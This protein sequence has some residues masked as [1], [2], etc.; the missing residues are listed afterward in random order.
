MGGAV[1][2]TGT[3]CSQSPTTAVTRSNPGTS[4]FVALGSNR[5]V[6]TPVS[7]SLSTS[8]R[9]T[10]TKTGFGRCEQRGCGRNDRHRGCRRRLRTQYRLRES[11][12]QRVRDTR[13]GRRSRTVTDRRR[14][15]FRTNPP[16]PTIR[17]A[18]PASRLTLSDRPVQE[19]GP[20]LSTGIFSARFSNDETG[21]LAAHGRCRV[22]LLPTCLFAHCFRSVQRRLD[23]ASACS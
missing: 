17:R 12:R 23:P 8:T 10:P 1:L 3:D 18:G 19:S 16:V 21:G 22:L 11:R 9:T 2:T 5:I 4:T 15:V 7:V 13:S 14:S 6:R 20:V